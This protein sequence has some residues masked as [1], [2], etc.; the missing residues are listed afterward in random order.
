MF[1][2]LSEFRMLYVSRSDTPF[3][4]ASEIFDSLVRI[5]LES[6]ITEDLLRYF[7]MRKAWDEKQY[8]DQRCRAD[9]PQPGSQ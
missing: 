4:R 6:D 8:A 9:F 1:R 3:E 2:Q 7:R 5:P